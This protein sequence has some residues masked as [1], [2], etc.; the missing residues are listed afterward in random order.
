MPHQ[1]VADNTPVLAG[2][3]QIT[4]PVPDPI[5]SAWSHADIAGE[6]A[7][8]AM[9]DALPGG[10]LASCIDTVAAVRTFADTLPI[11]NSPF[12]GPDNFP[13][14]IAARL[15]FLPD[16][17]VYEIVGG[18]SPQRLVG[19][20]CEKLFSGKVEVALIVGGEVIANMK[21]A[22]RQKS[23][24]NWNET[25]GGPLDDR[26]IING[27]P[28][29]TRLEEKHN[30]RFPMQIYGLMENARRKE[31]KQTAE[32]YSRNMG[33]LFSKLSD[34][35]ASNPYAAY[36]KAF[37]AET[38]V[39]ATENNPMMVSPYTKHLIARDTVNQGAALI[40]TTA[41]KARTLGIDEDKWIYLHG[42]TDC[43]DRTLLERNKLGRSKAMELALGGALEAADIAS[44]QV[45]YFDLYSC[46]PVVVSNACDILGI[47]ME[48]PRP[49]TTT[50]GLPFFGG[51]GNNY[52]M[53]GIASLVEKL[54][55]DPGRFG[56]AYANGGWMAKHSAG[57][58]SKEPPSRGWVPCSSKN[59]QTLVDSD[60]KPGIEYQPTGKATIQS[61][62]I[63]YDKGKPV[64]GII[65][66]SLNET[67]KRFLAVIDSKDSDTFEQ[68]QKTDP[69]GKTIYVTANPDGNRFAFY[70]GNPGKNK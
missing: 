58:Y 15:G 38:L 36:P 21:A 51:P 48:D 60:F 43:T 67:K 63:N 3:G 5:E 39:T 19:E 41:G 37:D 50:G 70:P 57:V 20:Y 42:Y 13:C 23:V 14:A 54:R 32:E 6:A 27:E 61:F 33:I 30:I 69:L 53:H 28:L 45:S 49:L 8:I 17:A 47:S 9:R 64:S 12:G 22:M 40:L 35:A 1:S 25:V 55:S 10:D 62:T 16:N 59:M 31:L 68:M 7:R 18:H 2:V 29:F 66:G 26:S 65:I 24:L 11:W 44:D 4:A 46:F 52:S 34:V 56:L